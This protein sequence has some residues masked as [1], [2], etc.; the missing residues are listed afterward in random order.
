[1]SLKKNVLDMSTTISHFI[2]WQTTVL[3]KTYYYWEGNTNGF[4]NPL[5]PDAH[6]S[7]RQDKPFSLQIQWLEVDLKLNRGFLF[8]APWELMG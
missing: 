2:T 1:M 6:Y 5:V 3:Y 4:I 7:E 8:F